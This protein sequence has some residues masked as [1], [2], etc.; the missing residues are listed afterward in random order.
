[1]DAKPLRN[2][3]NKVDGIIKIY[4]GIRYLELSNSYNEVFYKVDSRKC[5]AI[6]DR[7]NYLIREKSG[8][9]DSINH[10]FAR[11]RIDSYNPLPIEK[12]LTFHAIILLSQLLIRIKITATI[13]YF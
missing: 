1:M 4:D 2:R 9:T 11:I 8:I 6:F 13:I 10:N 7:I 5:N 12:K 3:F